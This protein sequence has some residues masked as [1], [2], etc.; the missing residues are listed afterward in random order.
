MRD[1]L[2]STSGWTG[3]STSGSTPKFMRPAEVEMLLADPT[4]IRQRTGLGADEVPFEQL[5]TMMVDADLAPVA[6]P[7]KRVL[8]TGAEGFV[9]RWLV[10][11]GLLADGGMQVIAAVMPGAAL[12]DEWHAGGPAPGAGGAAL[13]LVTAATSVDP[14]RAAIPRRWS[15]W[16]PSLPVPQRAP[17][18]PAGDGRSTR[19]H[20]WLV[21]ALAEHWPAPRDPLLASRRPKCTAR[22]TPRRSPEDRAASLRSSPYAASKAGG[23]D[24]VLETA[25]RTRASPWSWSRA[26]SLTPAR[27]RAPRIVLPALAAR[28]L[29]AKRIR[30]RPRADRRIWPPSGTFSM[31]ATWWSAYLLPAGTGG[32]R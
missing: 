3:R 19:R 9:G 24:G 26:R 32:G 12:P 4:W 17:R 28:L 25:R 10:R 20:R 31:C 13:D 22:V 21:G 11:A 29:E 18:I 8:V 7:M 27:A 16:P 23:R 6:G 30:S 5:I 1:C 2:R 15:T 14:G